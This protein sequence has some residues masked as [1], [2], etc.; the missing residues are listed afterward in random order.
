[1]KQ[2]TSLLL[3]NML[4]RL[5]VLEKQ[6]ETVVSQSALDISK[7]SERVKSLNESL[8][9]FANNLTLSM[10]MQYSIFD[11]ILGLTV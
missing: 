3:Q 6:V 7:L 2:T 9:S 1:M 5:M 11:R 8:R 4:D 10:Y